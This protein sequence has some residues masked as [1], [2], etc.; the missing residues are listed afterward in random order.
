MMY[1]IPRN[2]ETRFTFFDGFGWFE[3]FIT[4]LGAALGLVVSL[5]LSIFFS[6]L[7][8]RIAAFLFCAGAAF[9]I[10]RP[11]PD[12]SFLELY[13]KFRRWAKSPKRYYYQGSDAN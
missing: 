4:L 11:T 7:F 12:G 2:V 6:S 5:I 3:L 9:F 1:P 8:L 13:S 10:T